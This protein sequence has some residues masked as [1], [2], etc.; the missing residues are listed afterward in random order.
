[1]KIFEEFKIG[2]MLIENRIVMAPMS[3]NMIKDGYVTEQMIKFFEERAAGGVGLI[4]IG[5]GIIASPHGKNV[6]ESL[7]I[8]DD[9]Y[10][11]KLKQ[12]VGAVKNKNCKIALQLSHGGRRA[13][14]VA[15]TGC[16]EVTEGK[17]PVAPSAIAHPVPGQVVP[18]ELTKEEI[19]ELIA[20]FGK[21]AKRTE[22][23]G[24][25]AIGLHCAHMYL[26]GEFISPWANK[27]NDEYGGTIEGRI[28]FIIEIIEEIKT[29]TRGALPLIVRM[30]GEEPNGGNNLI[31]IGKIAQHIER[32]GADAI[33]V[34]VG[35]GA[36]SRTTEVI[37]SVTAMREKSGCIVHLAE[38]IKN[39]VKIPVIAVNKIET[40]EEAEN[41][42]ENNRADLISFGRPLIAD[43]YFPLK[44]KNNNIEEIRPCIYCCRG[45]LQNVL[46]KDLPVS[47]SV[48]PEVGKEGKIFRKPKIKKKI[49]ILGA[50][51]AGIQAAL[52]ADRLGHKVYLF[53]KENQIGGDLS[54][55]IALESKRPVK[56][57]LAYLKRQLKNSGVHLE[58]NRIIN[59]ETIETI[60]PDAVIFATGSEPVK[61]KIEGVSD[62]NS[63]TADQILKGLTIEGKQV[64]V[65]GGG[66]VGCEVAEFLAKKGKNV[67]IVE[68]LNDIALNV[69]RI[70]RVS[71][72]KELDKLNV[73][74]FTKSKIKCIQNKFATI[75]SGGDLLKLKVDFVVIAVGKKPI[76]NALENFIKQNTK[77]TYIIGDRIRARGILE[78]V[79]E[80]YQIVLKL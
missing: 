4:T 74:I 43:P 35:F 52:T 8:D 15:A 70:N 73:K 30:N 45:C 22:K 65:I 28:K 47:C 41:I 23:A 12:L 55:A 42:I 20:E 61:L 77:E 68:Q 11:P 3:L 1:M 53:E 80:G 17:I 46:E 66:A 59:K 44:S 24:F 62:K 67:V 32:A 2:N 6:K 76:K 69:D 27:R 72:L 57:Y 60:S 75:E 49:L 54:L 39:Y 26:C 13:G 48:N 51:P 63:A 29:R 10:I 50:G 71:L 25:D 58:L 40:I 38:N 14:R 34:S 19:K 21:A 31:D 79:H 36:P 18:K 16:L 7:L 64:L 56:R 9:K 37:P 78:A 33:H 5:D